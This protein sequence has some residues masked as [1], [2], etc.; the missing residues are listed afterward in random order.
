MKDILYR[1]RISHTEKT[2]EQLYKT[3]YFVYEKPRMIARLLIGFS[4]VAAAVAV[5]LP[6]WGRAVLLLIGAWLLVSRDFPAAVRA[7]KALTERKARLPDMEYSFWADKIHLS[8]EGNMDISYKNLTR[9]VEDRQYLYLFL[10]RNSVCMMEKASL[11]P[12]DIMAFASFLE[13][14]TGLKWQAEKPF[15]SLSLYDI[16]QALRDMRKK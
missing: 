12:A 5:A 11:K 3:Q 15:L 9:L 1:A 10:D 14:K 8:G 6:T 16:R 13:E 7:D 2:I 4:L